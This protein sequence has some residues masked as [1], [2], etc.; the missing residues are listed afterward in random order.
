[1]PCG[2]RARRDRRAH[3]RARRSRGVRAIASS[4]GSGALLGCDPLA[5]RR[6]AREQRARPDLR[7]P[8]SRAAGARRC[9]DSA[10][11]GRPRRGLPSPPRSS[12]RRPPIRNSRCESPTRNIAYRPLCTP[13]DIRS[14]TSLP[15]ARIRPTSRSVRRIAAAEAHARSACSSPSNH[16]SIASPPNFSSDP[17]RVIGI[18]P[19]ALRSTR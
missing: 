2:A 4:G 13:T 16:R 9:P 11:S 7:C 19:A 12:R 3:A 6:R 1:M 8:R 17:P 10:G 5:R 18:A 14:T 15:P